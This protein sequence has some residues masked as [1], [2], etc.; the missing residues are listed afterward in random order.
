MEVNILTS[1]ETVFGNL[2]TITFYNTKIN[3]KLL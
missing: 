1:S 2:E 3:Q